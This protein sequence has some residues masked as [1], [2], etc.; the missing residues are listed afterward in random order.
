MKNLPYKLVALLFVIQLQINT[1]GQNTIVEGYIYEDSTAVPLTYTKVFFLGTQ[2]GTTTDTLGYFKLTISDKLLVADTLVASYLGYLSQR[3]PIKRGNEQQLTIRLHSTL[4]V[5]LDE[6]KVVAG[7]NIA[8][9]YMR[10]IIA[11]KSENNPDNLPYYSTQ[12][13]AKIR[14]DLNS[15]TDKIK[16]NIILRPFDYIWDN[17]GITEDGVTYLPVLMTEKLTEHY[18]QQS[19]QDQKEIVIGE[20]TT[21]LAGPQ[22]IN[23][24]NDLY[25]TPNI[26]DN[27]VT[28]L[29]KSFPSPL[30]DNYQ[31]NYKFYLMDSIYSDEGVTYKIRF[32][33]KHQRELGF[34]GDMYIDSGSYAVKEINLRFDVMANVNFVRSYYIS[35]YYQKT[36]NHWMLSESQVLGDFTVL[37]NS[38]DL[39][40]FFGRKK[41][42]FS[43]YSFTM[44]DNGVFKGIDPIK[45]TDS[46]MVREDAFWEKYRTERL[47]DEEQTLYNVTQRVQ[48]DPAFKLRKNL[49]LTFG[50]GYIPLKG[51]QLGDIYSFYSYNVIEKSRFKFGLRTNPNNSFPLHLSAYTAYG[52]YDKRWKYGLSTHVDL[53]KKGITRIGGSYRY[54]IDQFGR[55]FNQIALD[56]VLSSLVQIGNSASRNYVRNLDLYFEK[57]IT[58]G[59]L[60]RAGYF[61]RDY[62]PTGINNFVQ[63]DNGIPTNVMKYHTAGFIATFKFSYLY[64]D[65]SGSF[66]DKKDLYKE[67]RKYPDLALMYENASKKIFGSNYDYQ[68][69]KVSVR[70]KVN[71]K[72]LG[73]LFYNVD[74][75]LTLGTVPHVSLDIPFGNQLVLADEYAFNLMQFMEFGADKYITMHLSHHFGGLLLD[76]VPLINKLKWRSFVFG[77]SYLG[78]I[79]AANNQQQYLFPKGMRGIQQTYYEVGFGF[80]NIFKIARIDFVWRLTPGIDQYYWFMVKPSFVFSF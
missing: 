78:S 5:E 47:S 11:K 57:S 79:S 25:I 67:V 12:Q 14:F 60:L 46:A 66:Y 18:Y 68:K 61:N 77:K 31:M 63:L 80:E 7:E 27:Y 10:K 23:F 3:I 8:W 55:S 13:Y 17:T 56:H 20:K 74:A 52:T 29:G 43:H 37:E 53:T 16:K 15:F 69:I 4:F 71:A 2:I 35:Q 48:E 30:N 40:G 36:E 1:F 54:D 75:G 41:A 22:L 39:T 65:I 34:V 59:L 38:S 6:V 9:R 24:T 33:P 21:G 28:I 45:Y 70:Q 50:T 49:I 72:K 64:K 42:L 26:Y 58:T 76:R 73:H 51:I 32:V 62:M 44:N 19:P